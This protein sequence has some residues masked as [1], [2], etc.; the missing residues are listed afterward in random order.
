KPPLMV[1]VPSRTVW[2]VPDIVPLDQVNAPS[3]VKVPAPLTVPLLS[4]RFCTSEAPLSVSVAK[5]PERLT[6]LVT[7]A[8]PLTARLPKVR[9]SALELCKLW[10]ELAPESTKMVA[11]PA[12]IVTSSLGPGSTPV[13]QFDGLV[14]F[15][16][17]PAP[18]Q[19][20]AVGVDRSS[21]V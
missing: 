18:V 14:Q 19:D 10:I 9:F 20:T 2:P 21:S 7:V 5:A 3:I 15:N 11:A 1:A 13:D 12:L 16:P 6:V 17:S 8:L 4:V